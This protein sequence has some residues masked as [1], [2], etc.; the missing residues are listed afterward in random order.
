VAAAVTAPAEPELQALLAEWWPTGRFGGDW[1]RPRHSNGEPLRPDPYAPQHYAAL[2]EAIGPRIPPSKRPTMQSTPCP[3]CRQP[4]GRGK[5]LCLRCWNQLPWD[6]RRALKRRDRSATSR[7]VELHRQ[8]K[9]D[10]PLAEIAV[11]P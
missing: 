6:A 11:S 3:S 5:Y 1:D 4:K 10:V 9:A 2:A 8:L 7:L